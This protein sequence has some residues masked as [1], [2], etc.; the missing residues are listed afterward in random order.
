MLTRK[1]RGPV[2]GIALYLTLLA[3]PGCQ[4]DREAGSPGASSPGGAPPDPATTVQLLFTYGSE[5]EEWIK[6]VT[7]SFNSGSFKT[8]GGKKILVEAV[9]QGSGESIDDILSE[10]R[11]PHLTS[12]ASAAFL[13]I[14]NAQSRAKTGK[15]LI[16]ETK[17]LVLSPVVIAMW[18]PMAEALGW[19]RQPVGWS[20]ILSL[21]RDPGVGRRSAI[22]SGDPSGWATP[23]PNTATAV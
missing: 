21:A 5:K 17:N 14:G 4:G 1:L 10:T 3:L 8:P 15:D 22:P 20:H 16:G 23:T 19:G 12:P 9:P 2:Q 7:A 11:K 13:R 6:D 18:K